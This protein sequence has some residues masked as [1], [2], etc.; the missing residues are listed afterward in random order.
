MTRWSYHIA[1]LLALVIVPEP[2]LG[3]GWDRVVNLMQQAFS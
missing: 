3:A 2:A 1:A